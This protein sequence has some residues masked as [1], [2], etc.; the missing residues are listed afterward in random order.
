MQVRGN[1]EDQTGFGSVSDDVLDD[2]EGVE[3]EDA[4]RPHDAL[5]CPLLDTP[6]HFDDC[7]L[8]HGR[9][10]VAPG[11]VS[12]Y[13]GPYRV[14]CMSCGGEGDEESGGPVT[15]TCFSCLGTGMMPVASLTEERY[16]RR[17]IAHLHLRGFDLR[18][19]R[20]DRLVFRACDFSQVNFDGA[21]LSRTKFER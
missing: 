8:C 18:G 11:D 15:W 14:P 3:E 17:P 4:E 19:L 21:D 6:I 2:D 1:T 20:L 9:G 7:K 10:W 16:R 13:L 12:A 5:T